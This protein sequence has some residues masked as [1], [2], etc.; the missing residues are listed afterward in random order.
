MPA[1]LSSSSH[2]KVVIAMA[3][4]FIALSYVLLAA[5]IAIIA[6]AL[7]SWIDPT[8]KTAIGMFLFKVT[9]P[10]IVP[11]RRVMPRTGMIDFSPMAALLIILL[12]QNLLG[13]ISGGR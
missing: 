13:R 1:I 4:L 3:L 2:G 8:G 7:F 11:L 9:D 6:R 10:M 5:Q 12:L